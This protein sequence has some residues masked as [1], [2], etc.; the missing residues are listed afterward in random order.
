MLLELVFTITQ[1]VPTVFIPTA[2]SPTRVE[3]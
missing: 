2:T 1:N 3:N